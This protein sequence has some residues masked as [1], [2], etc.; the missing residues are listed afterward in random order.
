LGGFPAL[1]DEYRDAAH[2][3]LLLYPH[4]EILNVWVELGLAGLVLFVAFIVRF[5]RLVVRAY[6]RTLGFERAVSLGLILA[7]T[8]LL[9]HGLVDAPYFK[10][11]LAELFFVLIIFAEFLGQKEQS[12]FGRAL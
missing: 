6:R 8:A 11:D 7:M 9:G 2:V 12:P 3:E 4:N 10:N 1:Y 5:Y